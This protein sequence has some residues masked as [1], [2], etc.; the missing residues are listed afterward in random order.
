MLRP[1]EIDVDQPSK[2]EQLS[3]WIKKVRCKKLMCRRN[4]KRNL[5]IE[6]VL[7]YALYKAEY[8]L[9]R[10]QLSRISQWRKL[11]PKFLQNSRSD[12]HNCESLEYSEIYQESNL[13]HE[14][15]HRLRWLWDG[16]SWRGCPWTLGIHLRSQD[17][18]HTGPSTCHQFGL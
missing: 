8:E 18:P 13:W 3:N 16:W 1:R 7:S 2:T 5:R 9:R 17:T 15:S 4:R 11:K 10:K 6:A 12:D 14:P